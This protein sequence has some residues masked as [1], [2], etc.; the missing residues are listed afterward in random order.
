[1]KPQNIDPHRALQCAILAGL[2]PAA[3]TIEGECETPWSSATFSGVQHFF[4]LTVAGDNAIA[5]ATN[6]GALVRADHV[7]IAG[8]II[9]DILLTS[10]QLIRP[11]GLPTVI[12][13]IEALTVS[14]N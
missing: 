7:A 11:S 5:A 2:S 1:M 4:D 12:I 8:H 14:A 6:L 3:V 9:A 10:H 13:G